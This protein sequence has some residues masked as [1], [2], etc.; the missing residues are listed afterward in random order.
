M[1]ILQI[2]MAMIMVICVRC[3]WAAGHP[4][5]VANSQSAQF[6]HNKPANKKTANVKI[7]HAINKI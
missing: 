3:I 5:T 7:N 4:E 1:I 6:V 2:G